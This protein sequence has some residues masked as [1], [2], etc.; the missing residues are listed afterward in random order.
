MRRTSVT[1]MGTNWPRCTGGSGSPS[2]YDES[3]R[4]CSGAA[5]VYNPGDDDE[6]LIRLVA[7][8]KQTTEEATATVDA[9]T[10]R[11]HGVMPAATAPGC[12]TPGRPQY[13]MRFIGPPSQS[14]RNYAFAHVDPATRR[15]CAEP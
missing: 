5:E 11:V 8:V 1:Q 14:I 7:Q 13:G 2:K 15:C 3:K 9:A 4:V 10:R 6:A 12:D